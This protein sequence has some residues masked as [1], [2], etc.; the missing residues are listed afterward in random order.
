MNINTTLIMEQLLTAI[1]ISAVVVTTVQ[2]FKGWFTSDKAVEIFSVSIALL[3][4]LAMSRYYAGYDWTASGWTAFYTVIGAEGLYLLI[5]EKLTKFKELK[6]DA[7]VNEGAPLS[8]ADLSAEEQALM[9]GS[10]AHE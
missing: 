5:A 6:P 9:R 4:G 1:I 2:R 3:L 8:Q 7:L 10:E